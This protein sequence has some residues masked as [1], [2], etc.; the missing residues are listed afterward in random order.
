[1]SCPLWVCRFVPGGCILAIAAALTLTLPSC[2]TVAGD[3]EATA[4]FGVT[5]SALYLTIENRTGTALIDGRI[6]IIPAGRAVLFTTSW[7]RL[8]IGDKRDF[9]LNVFRGTDGTPFRRG[10]VRARRVRVTATDLAG[11]VYE[12]IVPFE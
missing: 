6:E 2:S 7:P 10:V 5:V 11:K 9:M 12:R 8:E 4:P 1:M 3:D